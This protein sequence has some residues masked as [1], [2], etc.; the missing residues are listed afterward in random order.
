LRATGRRLGNPAA[1][2]AQGPP[3]NPVEMGLPDIACAVYRASL[4]PYRPLFETVWGLQAFALNWPNDTE[5]VCNNP[6]PPSA[7]D[8][9]PVHLNALDRGRAAATF[10]QMAQSIAGY[11]ASHEVTAFSSKFD[12]VMGKKAQFTP[13]EQT[14]YDPFRGKARCNECHRDGGPG[15]EP[16]FTDFTASNIGTPA[17]PLLPYYAEGVPDARG[18]VANPSGKLFVDLGVGGFLANG[19]PLSQPS[20]IDDTWRP[21]APENRGRLRVPTL[22]N[23]DKRPNPDFV[24]AY[25]HNGYFKSLKTIVHFYNTRDV[26]PRCTPDDP[27]EGTGCWPASEATDN[28]N[29]S[30]IGHLGLSDSEEDALVSFMQTLTDGFMSVSE[31]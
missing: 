23:V 29:T 17:N 15:E 3:T 26:L 2:Q 14:G 12:A 21:L 16:L 8:P 6:G 22:R 10:D 30:K 9:L 1:E 13:Q 28:M 31:K 4:R 5:R 18:Y 11:E 19:H 7:D 24:K 27:R 20:A 25:G